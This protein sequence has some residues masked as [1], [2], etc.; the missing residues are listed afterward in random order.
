MFFRSV[1]ANRTLFQLIHQPASSITTLYSAYVALILG[2]RISWDRGTGYTGQVIFSIPS[3]R[4]YGGLGLVVSP[5]G[6]LCESGS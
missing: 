1:G 3:G 6:V 4:T 5:F 2:R